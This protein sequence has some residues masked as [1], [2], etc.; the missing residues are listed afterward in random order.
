MNPFVL[1]YT[2][3]FGTSLGNITLLTAAIAGVTLTGDY[4]ATIDSQHLYSLNDT[5]WFFTGSVTYDSGTNQTTLN[6]C[7]FTNNS[8]PAIG[9]YALKEYNYE[10]LPV[11]N[12]TLSMIGDSITW[13]FLYREILRE[14]GL[15]YDFTGP[16]IDVYGFRHHGISGMTT[17]TFIQDQLPYIAIADSY[18]IMLGVNDVHSAQTPQQTV[19]NILQIINYI[20]AKFG[21]PI[22]YVST[23]LKTATYLYPHYLADQVNSLLRITVFPDRVTLIDTEAAMPDLTTWQTYLI[24]GIH[25]NQLGYESLI[26]PYLVGELI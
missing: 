4:T 26:A 3:V 9:T 15:R 25:P 2:P 24:D 14:A 13:A 1:E 21:N 20:R 18:L 12:R 8:V 23:I 6:Y 22:I 5:Y 11:Y 10:A 19:A 16:N 17:D 7:S